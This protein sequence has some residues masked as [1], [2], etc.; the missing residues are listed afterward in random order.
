MRVLWRFA[1]RGLKSRPGRSTLTLLS[2]VIGVAAVVSVNVAVSGS[3]ASFKELF[4]SLTG[5]AALEIVPGV[6]ESF[7][8]EAALDALKDVKGIATAVPSYQGVGR[9]LRELNGDKLRI[10]VQVIGIDP[11]RDRAVRDYEIVGGRYFKPDDVDGVLLEAAFAKR[12]DLNVGDDLAF[13]PQHHLAGAPLVVKVPI[14]GLLSAHGVGGFS[15]APVLVVPL[16]KA[17]GVLCPAGTVNMV[18]LVLSEN[19]NMEAV[20]TA[21]KDKIKAVEGTMVREP[22][23]RTELARKTL[24]AAENGLATAFALSVVLA[25]FVIVNT[26]LMNVSER[27]RQIAI[28]RAVGTT[29]L[30]VVKILLV[31]ALIMGVVGSIFG[32]ALGLCGAKFLATAMGKAYGTMGTPFKITLLPFVIAGVLG[33]TLALV[34]MI[35][36]AIIVWR[37]TPLE[38]MRPVIVPEGRGVSLRYSLLSI[39]TFVALGSLLAATVLNY[40]PVWLAPYVGVGL[41]GSFVLVVP[42][43]LGLFSSVAAT[44]MTPI[45]GAEG[46]IACRQILRRRLRTALTIGVLYI[47]ISAAISLGTSIINTVGDLHHWQDVTLAGDFFIQPMS[48]SDFATGEGGTM[49]E[50][51]GKKVYDIPGVRRVDSVR[52]TRGQVGKTAVEVIMRDA[53]GTDTDNVL[54]LILQG[55]ATAEDVKT[56]MAHGEVVVGTNLTQQ[57]GLH[58]G[59]SLT[60]DVGGKEHRLRIAAAITEYMQ[61][62]FVIHMDYNVGKQ[63]LAS[64]GVNWYIVQADPKALKE[65][66][67][68]LEGIC[69]AEGVLLRSSADVRGRVEGMLNGVVGSLWGLLVLLFVVSG[70]GVANTLTMNVLE[71]TRELAL[72]R[73]VA[74]T[75]MQVRKTILAQAVLIGIIG[76]V[77]GLIGGLIGAYLNNICALPVM[78]RVIPFNLYPGLFVGSGCLALFVIV[79]AALFPAE[80]AARLNLLIALQYE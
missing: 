56:R 42:V 2:I 67:H 15:L 8:E 28:L 6:D 23:K 33:P 34:A 80:R 50:S 32:T 31:E 41:T 75:R 9:V 17:Q 22:A 58:P 48:A 46:R 7:S 77:A 68:K 27:R 38:G 47:A 64:K 36:P 11:E 16:A 19:A 52:W 18:S 13:F 55:D 53:M 12:L 79:I 21:V 49:D 63:F 20:E 76:L 70:F 3:R 35:F 1:L 25:T 10:N 72:L 26:F 51:I 57:L 14:I 5:R 4:A 78:G 74:A 45:L 43:L 71:Q 59:D 24:G 39:F 44:V 30:Q 73:V 37:I 29:R 62:G 66:E 65:V 60:L 61:G 54:N 40:L 69:S